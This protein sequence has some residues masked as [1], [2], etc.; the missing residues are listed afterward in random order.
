MVELNKPIRDPVDRTIFE[1]IEPII[2]TN[3]DITIRSN[4]SIRTLLYGSVINMIGPIGAPRGLECVPKTVWWV[5]YILRVLYGLT[6]I[7]GD[8]G[9]ETL[10]A[11][12]CGDTPFLGEALK[13][14]LV[15][16]SFCSFRGKQFFLRKG[17]YGAIFWKKIWYL[18]ESLLLVQLQTSISTLP[19]RLQFYWRR[20]P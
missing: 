9:D 15:V 19:M 12:N 17:W 6:H 5:W 10:F 13:D 11:R 8:M 7:N 2:I 14:R 20:N 4:V 3:K 16:L 1:L 18:W